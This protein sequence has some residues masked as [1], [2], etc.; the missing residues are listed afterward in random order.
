MKNRTVIGAICM[1]MAIVVTFLVAPVVNKLSSDTT[2]VIRLSS[3]IK[4]GVQITSDNLETVNVKS[5]SVPS[6]IINDPEQII[7]KYAASALYAG[8]YL[9]NAKLAGE[10][11]SASDVFASLD[12]SKLAVSVT[13]N[14]FAS[15]LSGKLEN[16]DIVS[17]IVTDKE[18]E[19]TVIPDALKYLKVITT[20]TAGGI[21]QDSIIKN[22][23]G[24]YEVP[25]TVTLLVNEEQARLLAQYEADAA[26]TVALVYRGTAE[27]AKKFLDIQEEYFLTM[28]TTETT[29]PSG[30]ETEA[31]TEP[32]SVYVKEPTQSEASDMSEAVNADE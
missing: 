25:S 6:G 31:S 23:D 30:T 24:S 13:I 21:D 5:D 16:G 29:A 12:G 4:Q 27:N 3:D 9:T 18:N 28:Q 1:A 7:G 15:G 10:P 22:E 17:I 20:T 14:T 2:E 8:D 32:T 26:L 19:S 11:N